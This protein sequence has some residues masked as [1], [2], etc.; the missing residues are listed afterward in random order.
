M[1]RLLSNDGEHD[2]VSGQAGGRTSDAIEI[3]ID[4]INEKSDLCGKQVGRVGDNNIIARVLIKI[5]VSDAGDWY[6]F[7]KTRDLNSFV[8]LYC[9]FI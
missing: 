2:F 9:K 4:F 5:F 7:L 8:G 6:Y 1:G 3:K